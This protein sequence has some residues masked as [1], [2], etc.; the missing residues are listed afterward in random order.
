MDMNRG[1]IAAVHEQ[2]PGMD[3][4][5]DRYHVSALMN[6]AI[7]DLRREQHPRLPEQDPQVITGS[8]FLL[9]SNYEKLQEDK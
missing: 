5:F 4:V 3:I 2:L 8:R 9:L 1:Y 6:M 7:E